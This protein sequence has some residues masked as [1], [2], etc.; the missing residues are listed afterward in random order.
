MT[1]NQDRATIV[2]RALQAGAER[3]RPALQALLTDDVRAWTPAL[4]TA[5]LTELIDELDRRDEAFSDIEL[6]VA[7]L[8]V[9]GD[10]ACVEWTVRMSHSGAIVLS[11]DRTIEPAGTRVT[12]HGVTVAEFLGDRICSFRQYWDEFSVLEQ[13]GVPSDALPPSGGR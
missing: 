3:D 10:Y 1:S 7:P 6:D 8:D 2:V 13:L 5:S 12:L 9:S 4:S 11:D